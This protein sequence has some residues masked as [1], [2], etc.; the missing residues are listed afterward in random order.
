M[1]TH[2]AYVYSIDMSSTYKRDDK[3]FKERLAKRRDV[4]ENLAAFLT[5]LEHSQTGVT[6]SELF[7]FENP[8]QSD[9]YESEGQL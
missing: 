6:G 4:I 9:E 2:C 5:Y 7:R 8:G 3:A 1:Y